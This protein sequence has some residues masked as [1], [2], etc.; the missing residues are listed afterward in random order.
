MKNLKTLQFKILALHEKWD[1]LLQDQ[2]AEQK[3]ILLMEKE[4]F[5][6][7]RFGL[8]ILLN[9]YCMQH[10]EHKTARHYTNSSIEDIEMF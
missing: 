9:N 7:D 4:F 1:I 10:E 6:I 8:L 3:Q 5:Q 2:E